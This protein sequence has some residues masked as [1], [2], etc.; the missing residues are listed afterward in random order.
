SR[1]DFGGGRTEPETMVASG[2][3][4]VT[5]SARRDAKDV[6]RAFADRIESN[7]AL[8]SAILYGGN[9]PETYAKLTRG[10]NDA[11]VLAGAQL[12]VEDFDQRALV[13]GPGFVR[14]MTDKDLNGRKLTAV[15]PVEVT[16]TEGMTYLPVGPEAPR[17]LPTDAKA[18]AALKASR[19]RLVREAVFTGA[20][21][22]NTGD[23]TMSC[24]KMVVEMDPPAEKAPKPATAPAIAKTVASPFDLPVPSPASQPGE[25]AAAPA[26]PDRGVL[27]VEDFGSRKLF[28][29][30]GEGDVVL[31][32]LRREDAGFVLRR[33]ESRADK[34]LYFAG[35][36]A[37]GAARIEVPGHGWLFNEDYRMEDQGGSS[38]GPSQT[39]FEWHKSMVLVQDADGSS[40]GGRT[41][42]LHGNVSMTHHSGRTIRVPKELM[43]RHSAENL[44]QGRITNLACE[45]M[46]AEFEGAADKKAPPK[47][48]S[49]PPPDVSAAKGDGDM[50]S[51]PGIGRMSLF[52][53]T[54]ADVDA[55]KGQREIPVQMTDGAVSIMGKRLIY[56]RQEKADQVA[57]VYGYLLGKPD[58][59]ARVVIENPMEGTVRTWES[60]K[61]TIL[62]DQT[63]K[64]IQQVKVDGGVGNQ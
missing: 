10:E 46:V 3:V 20:V 43:V 29:V 56:N 44:P 6:V 1:M 50:M 33:L 36:K 61:I 62:F 42:I 15:R 22:M 48:G 25:P 54:G 51:G 41:A 19:L 37:S 32:S 27:T 8:K 47:P 24:K 21:L 55:A 45:E 18:L 13:K 31:R 11:N 59:N 5:D 28:M 58:A 35:S 16:W 64:K 26:P 34:L 23:D 60:P 7:V 30:S 57:N 14:F 17:P 38:E 4:I 53:A 2:R 39:H 49:L 12:Q 40:S 52:S 63:G 9:T